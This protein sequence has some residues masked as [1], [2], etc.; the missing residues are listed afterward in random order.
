VHRSVRHGKAGRIYHRVAVYAFHVV[1]I[2]AGGLFKHGA[3]LPALQ[4]PC[5][6]WWV[7]PCYSVYAHVQLLRVQ[8]IYAASVMVCHACRAVQAALFYPALGAL[9]I[10]LLAHLRLANLITCACVCMSVMLCRAVQLRCSTLPYVLRVYDPSHMS[11]CVNDKIYQHAVCM[12]SPC[13]AVQA[14]LFYPA[15][16]ASSIWAHLQTVEDT[17]ALRQA[18]PGLGLVGFVGDGAILPRKR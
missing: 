16:D 18:L 9:S 2:Q 15:L 4:P 14:A 7:V 1:C 3:G 8:L 17:E 10:S 6:S 12:P 11:T 13:R 5:L